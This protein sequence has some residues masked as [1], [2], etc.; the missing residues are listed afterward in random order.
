MKKFTRNLN[1]KLKNRKMKGEKTRR[2]LKKSGRRENNEKT[3]RKLYLTPLDNRDLIKKYIIRKTR[4]NKRGFSE[5]K[6]RNM[7]VSH[8]EIERDKYALLLY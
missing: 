2:N 4:I 6:I 1:K 3:I 5:R 8:F 7:S